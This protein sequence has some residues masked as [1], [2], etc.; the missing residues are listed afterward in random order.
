MANRTT[1]KEAQ[2]VKKQFESNH[3]NAN[4]VI[5]DRSSESRMGRIVAQEKGFEIVADN[6]GIMVTVKETSFDI[7]ESRTCKKCGVEI[8]T[9]EVGAISADICK[10]CTEGYESSGSEKFD[11][12]AKAEAWYYAE[13]GSGVNA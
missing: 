13:E 12:Y 3:T 5:I 8:L 10:N 2:E 1:L 6:G 7:L 11:A 4:M 9:A